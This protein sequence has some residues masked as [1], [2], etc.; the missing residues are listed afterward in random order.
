MLVAV[1]GL[2]LAGA[3]AVAQR[4]PAADLYLVG[5]GR[6]APDAAASLSSH[7]EGTLKIPIRLL[8]PLPLDETAV[9]AARSQVVAE[10]VIGTMQSKYAALAQDPRA[11]VIGITGADMYIQSMRGRW[12]FAFSQRS[13]DQKFAIVSYARM[14]PANFGLPSD[15]SV[16]D[17][18]LRKMVM[19]NI[20]IMYFGLPASSN[21]RSVLYG[22]ILGNDD[23]DRMT[24][25]FNPR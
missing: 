21:P 19:K 13:R 25:D 20:G 17:S 6:E 24:E 9:D 7:F 22:N 8:T 4:Q 12:S 5:V 16:R 3:L 23:L 15:D 2:G 1:L 14:D 10:R 11:R 18:R